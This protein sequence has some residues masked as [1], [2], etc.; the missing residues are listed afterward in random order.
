MCYFFARCLDWEKLSEFSVS[1][2]S[3]SAQARRGPKNQWA[4]RLKRFLLRLQLRR[5]GNTESRRQKA[6]RRRRH[7]L[8]RRPQLL[9]GNLG[10]RNEKRRQN[11]MGP[12]RDPRKPNRFREKSE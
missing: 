2:W 6:K 3:A 8:F 4:T 1:L 7:K 11:L 9:Q 12:R 10:L 5:R